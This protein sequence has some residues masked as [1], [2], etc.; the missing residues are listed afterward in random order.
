MQPSSAQVERAAELKALLSTFS[1]VYHV[2]DAPTMS[3]A[4]Y[5]SLMAELKSIEAQYPT[6]IT[7]DSPTQ[8]VGSELLGGF[9]KVE[10]KSRMLS[11]NDVFDVADVEAW[12]VRIDKLLPNEKHDFF[13]DIKMDG[14]YSLL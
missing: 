4:V 2:L 12:V 9:S 14:L 10:H 5:D 8:R 13:A 7:P 1:Y 3:D 6:L 11:L